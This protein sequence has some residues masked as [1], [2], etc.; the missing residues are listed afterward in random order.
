MHPVFS[1][2]CL[3]NIAFGQS[4]V[5]SQNATVSAL[6]Y[7]FPLTRYAMLAPKLLHT[8]LGANAFYHA[9][10][11]STADDKNVV[12]P[13]V[14]TIYSTL[15]YDLSQSNVVVNVPEVPND[16]YHLFSYYDPF[17][18]NFAN[19]GSANF[20]RHGQY[21]LRLR[22]DSSSKIGLTTKSAGAYQAYIN[23]PTAYSLI[24]IRWLVNTTN[25]DAVHQY[26]GQTTSQNE[27]RTE[28]TSEIPAL[29]DVFEHLESQAA[30][31]GATPNATE[32]TLNLLAAFS[33][34]CPPENFS[35]TGEVKTTLTD[36]GVSNG[37]YVTP[38][39]VDLDAANAT[40]LQASI[41]P[42]AAPQTLRELN[43]GWSM[44]ATE[45][46]GD[47]GTNYAIRAVI[48]KTGYLMLKAPNAIYPPWKNETE[49]SSGQG[50]SGA[51]Q[52]LG[53]DEALL[54][55]FVGGRPPLRG[56]G[57]WSLTAYGADNFLIDNSLG[58]YALGDR[59]N[60]TYPNGSKVY[61]KASNAGS[62]QHNGSFQILVQAANM[63]PP[64]NWTSNWLPGPARGGDLQVLLRF[65]EAG[66]KLLDG[67]YQYP[68]VSRIAAITNP[69][70]SSPSSSA[71]SSSD[72]GS[73]ATALAS[74]TMETNT[75]GGEQIRMAWMFALTLAVSVVLL[76][77]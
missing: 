49:A 23:S 13:N 73:S 68:V 20:D 61:D 58:V 30:A 48:A 37:S 50:L 6:V 72:G 31:Y 8:P 25:L 36:S 9:Q 45:Y 16:Q 56:S 18:N 75:G 32:Q 17:G 40:A 4:A 3:V 38:P 26:Q 35:M 63:P 29:L 74:G 70:S 67:T 52:T 62:S 28:E 41:A 57:F 51:T 53:S 69:S 2:V 15:I 54:Y 1:F 21:R 64:T 65:Y 44:L 34:Y 55:D 77:N 60:L 11:L 59:S 12:K 5:V 7:G 24:L 66:D 33:P 46:T 19:T 22:P 42:F 10:K 47:F 76:S 71:A 14:D 39:G 43:H 27:T